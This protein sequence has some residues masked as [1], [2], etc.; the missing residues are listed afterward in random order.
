MICFALHFVE[1]IITRKVDGHFKIHANAS[2]PGSAAIFANYPAP[3]SS[4]CTGLVEE[5]QL[6]YIFFFMLGNVF[7]TFKL[8]VLFVDFMYSNIYDC[9]LFGYESQVFKS[10]QLLAAAIHRFHSFGC[11]SSL[12]I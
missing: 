8:F 3:Y 10:P 4:V 12:R 2:E 1:A 7:S 5:V 9:Y 6:L 11:W